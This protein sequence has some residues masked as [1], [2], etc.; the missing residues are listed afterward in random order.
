MFFLLKLDFM[1]T[2]SKILETRQNI[3]SKSTSRLADREKRIDKYLEIAE[4][5]WFEIGKELAEI[6]SE[7]DY[8]EKSFDA[9]V[10]R[11]WGKTRDWGYKLIEGYRVKA[12]LPKSV[13]NFIQN[14]GQ[15]LALSA[16]PADKREEVLV[17]VTKAK[18]TTAKAIAESVE[19]VTKKKEEPKEAEFEEC[20][21]TG[22]PI[23]K[24]LL[25]EWKR[26]EELEAQLIK[27]LREVKKMMKAGIGNDKAFVRLDAAHLTQIDNMIHA[28]KI[29][30]HVV[31]R[32]CHGKGCK[33]CKQ[34]GFLTEVVFKRLPKEV[35]D[36]YVSK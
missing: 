27:P 7:G 1:Q 30:P 3:A 31:C 29:G 21:P 36:K 17:E 12:G 18:K 25:S 10:K 32:S 13:E 19:K 8:P 5:A 22:T 9:Y 23:P 11:R 6:Q 35:Q 2:P 34:Q 20:D 26:S 4:G 33:D 28:L 15:A 16:A 14:Q 24:A